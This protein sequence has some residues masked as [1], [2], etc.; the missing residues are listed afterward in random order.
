M[1][2]L[3][4]NQFNASLFAELALVMF[5]LVFVAIVIRTLST[6]TETINEQA[7]IVLGDKT[8]KHA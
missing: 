8:E 6:R 3:V 4:L 1:I 2:K 5:A 7:N